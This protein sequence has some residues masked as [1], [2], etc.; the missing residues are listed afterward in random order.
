[1]GFIADI[2]F[3]D[4]GK[5]AQVAAANMQI[6]ASTD[7]LDKQIKFGTETRDQ[8]RADQEPFRQAGINA[9]DGVRAFTTP[10]ADLNAFLQNEP[11][12]QAGMGQGMA[13]ITGSAS[14]N[15][16]MNS[17]ATLKAINRYGQ[18]YANQNLGNIFNRYSTA[19]GMG[20][21]ANNVNA[22]ASQSFANNTQNALG[23]DVNRRN[24]SYADKGNARAG[25][26]GGVNG[27]MN[28]YQNMFANLYGGF[29]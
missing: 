24:S 23:A 18:D 5:D 8:I 20:S 15:G 12:Y 10:G 22:Q 2:F 17:G 26:W 25:F 7:A 14:R 27:S 21:A 6:H 19:A 3:Q 13:A 28:S 4:K 16:L 1:M 29:G 11:G 9:L